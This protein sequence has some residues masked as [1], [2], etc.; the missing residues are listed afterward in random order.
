[1]VEAAGVEPDPGRSTNRLM[2]QD[3]RRNNM[4]PR[5]F[6]PSI[7]SPGVPY[8]PLESTPV[9]ETFWRRPDVDS[10]RGPSAEPKARRRER[11]DPLASWSSETYFSFSKSPMLQLLS[12]YAFV[13]A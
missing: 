1:M 11:V 6:P 3:F 9:L 5:R 4:I 10:G 12:K 2:A 8:S 13:G 7:E